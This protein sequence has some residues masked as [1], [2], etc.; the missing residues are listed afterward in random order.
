MIYQKLNKSWQSEPRINENI[1]IHGDKLNIFEDPLAWDKSKE[2]NP[3]ENSQ[4][5]KDRSKEEGL[6]DNEGSDNNENEEVKG[7]DD[8]ENNKEAKS[9]DISENKSNKKKVKAKINSKRNKNTKTK[10]KGSKTVFLKVCWMFSEIS[11]LK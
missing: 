10:K 2:E 1:S 9:Q 8:K 7:K 6:N 11:N 3:N 4:D 5:D